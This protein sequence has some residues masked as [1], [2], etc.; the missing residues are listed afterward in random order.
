MQKNL[1][2]VSLAQ[3][4]QNTT[5]PSN[6]DLTSTQTDRYACLDRV[7][8]SHWLK[9]RPGVENLQV[10]IGIVG[11]KLNRTGFVN[12]VNSHYP[13][14]IKVKLNGQML[15]AVHRVDPYGDRFEHFVIDFAS[16]GLTY[17]PQ[18]AMEKAF[19]KGIVLARL[20]DEV[21]PMFN[22]YMIQNGQP[23]LT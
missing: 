6:W 9:L 16:H 15:T 22:K 1:I 18:Q 2:A 14:G 17:T 10:N 23:A 5:R 12:F 3:R 11:D 21:I 4:A 8:A 13:H 7:D 20:M 19:D